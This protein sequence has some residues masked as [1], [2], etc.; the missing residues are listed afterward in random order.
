MVVP[1]DGC[2][3]A[4]LLELGGERLNDSQWRSANQCR[5]ES[6][7]DRWQLRNDSSTL[8]CVL[9]DQRVSINAPVTL[10]AGD[11]LEL[12]FLRIEVEMASAVEA[13]LSGASAAGRLQVDSGAV[14]PASQ[15]HAPHSQP[16]V[17]DSVA[18]DLRDLAAPPAAGRATGTAPADSLDDP[19]GVLGIAGAEAR[20]AADTLAELLGETMP[21][22]AK[23]TGRSGGLSANALQWPTL[24]V[25]AAPQGRTSAVTQAR[26]A[27]EDPATVR[28]STRDAAA[29]LLDGLHEEFVRVVRDPEQL[30]GNA[31]WDG[32]FAGDGE[33]A[34]TLDELSQRAAAYPLLRDILMEREDIDRVIDD[35]DP[36][37]PS[38]LLD[39]TE[40][41]DVLHLFAPEL[42]HGAKPSLPSLTR[43]E[44]HEVSPDSHMQTGR[45]RP[46]T[47]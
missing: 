36:L 8:V 32:A 41:D 5:I 17:A 30:G 7:G 26:G 44:H 39:A 35:F 38:T 3:F 24:D 13:A 12:G 43:R 45:L 18:F 20:P 2:G 19:F 4:D 40:I 23:P 14:V 1:Q 9:N 47:P 46:D 11:T 33:K 15:S 34:P 37:T 27:R 25:Q 21:Q 42:V 6:A 31:D 22:A 16:A 28:G 10:G 29:Q